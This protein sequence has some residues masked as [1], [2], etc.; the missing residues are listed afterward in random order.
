MTQTVT[1]EPCMHRLMTYLLKQCGLATVGQMEDALKA[2]KESHAKTE[3][4]LQQQITCLNKPCA[5]RVYT[6]Q[7]LPVCEACPKHMVLVNKTETAVNRLQSAVD[8][9][10]EMIESTWPGDMMGQESERRLTEEA[11]V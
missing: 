6:P 1:Q 9:L 2:L 11:V 4:E 5:H 3:Q 7:R 8:R 10:E